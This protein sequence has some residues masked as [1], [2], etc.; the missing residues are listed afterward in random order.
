[1]KRKVENAEDLSRAIAELELKATAK[2]KEIRETFANVSENLKPA[3]LIKSGLRSVFSGNHKEELV[4]ILIGVGTG[5]LSRKLLLGRPHGFV[6]K[7]LGKALQWGMAGLVSKNAEK[8][9]E[10]AGEIID[11]IFRKPKPGF[12]HLPAPGSE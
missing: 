1:M 10:K 2:K 11:R 5:F 9:K 7:T 3:N 8:I 6:G 12:N 4:N